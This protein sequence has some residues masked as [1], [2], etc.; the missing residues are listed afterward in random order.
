[1]VHYGARAVGGAGLLFTEMTCVTA[2]RPH[3]A[4]LHRHVW[5]RPRGGVEAHRRFRARQFAGQNLPAARPCRAKGR[6]QADVGGHG[7]AAGR[8]RLAHR[9][10]VPP[11]LFPAQPGA[12]RAH[13]RRHGRGDRRLVAAAERGE[14]AGFDMLELHCAHGY[15]L[16]SFISPLTN[17][18]TDEYGGSLENRLRF[19]LQ[20]FQRHARLLAQAQADVGAHLGHRLE[21]RRHHRRGFGGDRAK[22]SPSTAPISSTCPPARRCMIPHRSSAACSRRRS[23]TRSATH[24]HRH[25]VRR[26]HH[27]RRP[28]QHD[29]R[30]RPRRPGGARPP[31][32]FS[33]SFALDAAAQYGFEPVHCPPQYLPGKDQLM[34]TWA[35]QRE[36]LRELRLKARPGGTDNAIAGIP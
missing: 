4:W 8:R 28:G 12:A 22:A 21:G 18:R 36:D 35:R 20:V 17:I 6:N 23:P 25:H 2:G 26:Q 13:A 29:P 14:R 10:G 30:R 3:H 34:R 5:R 1:M 24:R 31:A 27:D 15:L 11:A 19:P 16:A 9:V 7:R 33:P 32:P